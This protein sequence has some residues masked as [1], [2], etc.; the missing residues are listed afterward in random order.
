ML[1]LIWKKLETLIVTYIKNI[2]IVFSIFINIQF[3]PELWRH[4]KRFDKMLYSKP[5][6][7]EILQILYQLNIYMELF[8]TVRVY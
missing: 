1:E 7:N 8:K 6:D 4:I 2:K 3:N 5:T